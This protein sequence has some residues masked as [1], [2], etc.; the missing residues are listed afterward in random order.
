MEGYIFLIHIVKFD[1]A[2]Y[3]ESGLFS[4]N[5]E[6][7]ER[8]FLDN[9]KGVVESSGVNVKRLGNLRLYR[10]RGLP[11]FWGERKRGLHLNQTCAR[12]DL[13]NIIIKNRCARGLEQAFFE[14]ILFQDDLVDFFKVAQVPDLYQI[15]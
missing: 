8:D 3:A 2:V 14:L 6:Y 7:F 5:I 9:L 11:K 12:K 15:V 1:L 4:R 13:L 10:V